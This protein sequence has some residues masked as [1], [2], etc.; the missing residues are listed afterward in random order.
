M[1]KSIC[2][3]RVGGGSLY[4]IYYYIQV[5]YYIYTVI[6]IRVRVYRYIYIGIYKDKRLRRDET[7]KKK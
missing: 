3:R 5:T 4:G 6:Y 7:G 1:Q 2:G